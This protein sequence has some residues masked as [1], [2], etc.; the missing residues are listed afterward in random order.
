MDSSPDGD[1]RTEPARDLPVHPAT[2]SD[3]PPPGEPT[4]IAPI[5]PSS[6]MPSWDQRAWPDWARTGQAHAGE[7][8]PRRAMAGWIGFSRTSLAWNIWRDRSRAKRPVETHRAGVVATAACTSVVVSLLTMWLSAPEG[9]MRSDSGG[10]VTVSYEPLD[11]GVLP[12]AAAVTAPPAGDDAALVAPALPDTVDTTSAAPSAAPPTPRLVAAPTPPPAPTPAPTPAPALPPARAPQR[13]QAPPPSQAS[14]RRPP[15][16][17]PAPGPSALVVITAPEGARVTINGMAYGTSP[18]TV[19][20]LPPG[21]KRIRVT[22]DGYTGEERVVGAD[23]A[24]D[25]GTL[26]IELREADPGA[27]R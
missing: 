27:L 18:V 14:P 23:L 19:R 8:E 5:D 16:A 25:G 4:G 7:M 24:R 15:V 12:Q 26:R 20:Y 10:T 13:A 11:A 22:K 3:G 17:S 21:A 6:V 9:A 2:P 1:H